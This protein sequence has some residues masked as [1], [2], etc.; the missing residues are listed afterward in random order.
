MHLL[1]RPAKGWPVEQ[2]LP[3]LEV[4]E[5]VLQHNRHTLRSTIGLQNPLAKGSTTFGIPRKRT[6][7]TIA[8]AVLP[9]RMECTVHIHYQ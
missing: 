6:A 3:G 1:H 9:C 8:R 7:G 2:E 4:Q 5:W